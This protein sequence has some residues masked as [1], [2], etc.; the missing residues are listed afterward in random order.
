MKQ[1]RKRIG[2]TLRW[3]VAV[4]ALTS[5]LLGGCGRQS[6][7]TLQEHTQTAAS[8]T[9]QITSPPETAP[10]DAPTQPTTA[11]PTTEAPTEPTTAAKT[12]LKTNGSDIDLSALEHRTEDENAPV[13]YFTKAIDSGALVN[14][15]IMLMNELPGK[16][17]VKLTTGESQL[18]NYLK[19]ELIGD[20]VRAVD[21]TIVECM[22]AYGGVRST[23]ALSKQAA[24]DRGYTAIADF[25]LLDEDGSLE[26]PFSGGVRINRAIVGSHLQNYDSVLV[27]SHF[28]G[29]L[30]AGF[31]G[32]I[33]NVGIGMSSQKGKIYVHSGGNRTI[34]TIVNTDQDAFLEALAEA[35]K[36]VSDYMNNGKNMLYISVMNRLSVDC[37]CM[38]LPAAPDMHDIG[39]LA[40][41][42]PVALDQA[43]VD[44]VYA[45]PDGDSLIRRMESLHGV[46]VL[47]HGEK[48][49]LGS[50]AYRLV[51]ID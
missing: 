15:Y 44:L 8:P 48:I 23:A 13:V 32:A 26:I 14:L 24:K 16:V 33:K 39:V 38:A 46:H 4:L 5:L 7:P 25:D 36:A 12:V 30:L 1:N 29:H 6:Q 20:L 43:C 10:T 45:A 2:K 47:E 22:T 9:E 34:G 18:T 3:A 41:A 37:D 17:A 31:G 35:V 50:R 27:L 28:K 49:G 19:P 42:D 40:S 11:T 51:C 21:G